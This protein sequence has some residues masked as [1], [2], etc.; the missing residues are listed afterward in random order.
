VGADPY[1]APP[2]PPPLEERR[3]LY[4]RWFGYTKEYQRQ[5]WGLL[6]FVAPLAAMT[7]I[8]AWVLKAFRVPF[9]DPI[10]EEISMSTDYCAVCDVCREKI[11]AGQHMGG[12]DSF[13]H[14]SNDVAGR[15]RV[16]TWIFDHAWHGSGV[17]IE[18]QQSAEVRPS[19]DYKTP[20]WDE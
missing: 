9:L 13:G 6:F 12:K 17:R 8:G 18:L 15:T 14:G 11:H 19:D 4:E 5:S 20:E 10:P 3:S 7:E 2:P 1:R 16:A